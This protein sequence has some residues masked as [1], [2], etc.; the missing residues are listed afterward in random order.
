MALKA[1]ITAEEHG[2]LA[3]GL[4][5]AYVQD[6]EG[7]KLDLAAADEPKDGAKDDAGGD[8]KSRLDEFRQNNIKLLKQLEEQ[9]EQ[10]KTLTAAKQKADDAAKAADDEKLSETQ[11]LAKRIEE[12]T[13][14]IDETTK[15]AEDRAKELAAEKMTAQVRDAAT[16]AGIRPAAV[17]DVIVRARGFGFK[18]GENG[19]PGHPENKTLDDF[20]GGL[21]Q[22]A[23]FLFQPT[24]GDGGGSGSAGGGLPAG[25]RKV[26]WAEYDTDDFKQAN[27]KDIAAGKI[28]IEG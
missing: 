11:K 5:A 8:L 4:R 12:L 16:K 26:S 17:E 20:F 6:G 28:V 3:E 15:T 2:A 10:I 14:K 21:K 18:P 9:G 19:A 24:A 25:V 23:D 7:Y 27:A 1:K 13:T 22:D